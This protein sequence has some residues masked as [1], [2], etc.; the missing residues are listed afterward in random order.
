MNT[1]ESKTQGQIGRRRYARS[2]SLAAVSL[3]A[4]LNVVLVSLLPLSLLA[5]EFSN[6]GNAS[7][8]LRFQHIELRGM[9][10][11]DEEAIRSQI[12][13]QSGISKRS[14]ISQQ[15]KSLYE[16]GFFDQVSA[17]L[18]RSTSGERVLVFS[19]S[20]KPVVR[21]VFI[22]GNMEID[23]KDLVPVFDF[24]QRRFLDAA[25]IR[26][27]IRQ[28]KAFYQSRGFFRAD[29][30]YSIAPVGDNQVD[31]TF[32]VTEGKRLKI[33]SVT[34]RG[35]SQIEESDLR[36]VMQTSRYKWWNSWLFGSGRLSEELLKNDRILIRQY[37][38]NHGYLDGTVSE[39]SVEV[40]DDGIHIS[41]DIEE[42]QVYSI[43]AVSAKGDLIDGSVAA[44]VEGV[45]LGIG[46][47][48]SSEAMRG[49]VFQ[50][51]EKF[52]DRGYAFANVVPDT[53]INPSERTVEVVYQI[54]KGKQVSVD[55]VKIKGNTKTYDNVIRREI[56][57]I[58]GETY[59]SKKLKRSEQLL[60]RLGYFEEVDISTDTIEG[61][62]DQVDL[63][64]NVREAATGTFSAGAGCSSGQGALFNARLSENNVF[65]SGKAITLNADLGAQRENF[66][67]SYRDRR[68]RDS[69]WIF[70]TELSFTEREFIDFD[71]QI[72]GGSLSLGYP[73]EEFFGEWSQDINF[74]MQYEYL[75]VEISNVDPADAAQFV[76]D[77]EG[78][79][80]ASGITPQLFRNTINNPLNPTNGS[81]Q[82]L[83]L[84]LTGLGGT[85]E[86]YLFSFRNQFYRPLTSFE[87]GT[88]VV[89]G[90]RTRFGYGETFDK[91]DQ[92]P[93]FRRF[94]PGGINSVRGFQARTLGPKDADGNEYGGSKEVVNSLEIIFPVLTSAGLNGVIFHDIGQAFDD[95]QSLD[96]GALRQAYGFGVRWSSPMGPI[97]VEFGFPLDKEDG[98]D[99][100]VT[101]FSF[102]APL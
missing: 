78:R 63:T 61:S 55:K 10:R 86:Y 81:R 41:F 15:I 51:T 29:F 96:F 89:L 97:R 38:L 16:T 39:P 73:L 62:D 76:I 9:Q 53:R 54:D 40:Q 90:W 33:R 13:I 34:F 2:F 91:N 36:D 30:D 70:G 98:E 101:L 6:Q 11:I 100:M 65:G 66:I 92:L 59:S 67:F 3:A 20:E 88:S 94:F 17:G 24:E 71:R 95:N 64:V 50:I 5:Q 14:D 99:G 69:Y 93:L 48:F 68:F 12:T 35:L 75:E 44:T 85:E 25:V 72:N 31:V 18:E 49:D 8:T 84:E 80:T 19:F 74:S 23:E 56:R 21:K 1:R 7:T 102:G 82:R 4:V 52:S 43:S 79:S 32:Q 22:Q 45:R 46:D 28:A 26:H 27:L 60:R 58:E 87:N 37:F 47:T 77:S 57:L 83:S 42:G